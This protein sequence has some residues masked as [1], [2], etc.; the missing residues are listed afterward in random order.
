M[1]NVKVKIFSDNGDQDLEAEINA[2][3]KGKEII[4]IKYSTSLNER[5][6]NDE[7]ILSSTFHSVLIMYSE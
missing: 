3:I 6:P 7:T 4:D 2:F 1:K 5:D